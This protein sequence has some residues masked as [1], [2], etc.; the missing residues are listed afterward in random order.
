[1]KRI[2]FFFILLLFSLWLG[3][4]MQADSG[5]IFIRYQNWSIETT[6]WFALLTLLIIGLIF[7][8]TGALIKA[9]I[10]FP[11]TISR[12]FDRRFKRKAERDMVK[13][14]TFLMEENPTF[15]EKYFVRAA[16][17]KN[18]PFINYLLAAEAA[19]KAHREPEKVRYLNKA[20]EYAN[21][22]S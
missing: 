7:K 19:R 3:L 20:A 14:F 18:L 2:I 6:V 22:P 5:S 16:G 17:H 9:I 21:H 8:V 15:A 11:T 4:K 1:M 10:K 12:S 13:G